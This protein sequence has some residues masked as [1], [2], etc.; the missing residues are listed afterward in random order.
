MVKSWLVQDQ[1]VLGKDYSNLLIADSLLKTIWFINAPCYG[2]E[3]LASPK[4]NELTIPEQTATGKGKSNPFMAAKDVDEDGKCLKIRSRCVKVFGY[5][6]QELKKINLKK[7]EVKQV[8]QSCL[9]EDCWELYIPDLVPVREP[10][11]SFMKPFGCPVTILNTLDPLGKFDGKAEEGFLVSSD[12]KVEDDTVDDDAFKK[13]VQKSASETFSPVGPSSG[14]SFVPFGGSFL[15]DVYNLP[16]DP[17][18]PELEDTV[19]I[20]S[21]SIFGNAYDDHDLETLNIP[22]ANQSVGAEADFNNME[23]SIVV[24]PIPTTRVHSTHP[25]A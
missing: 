15:I 3:A 10:N 2:N 23:P 25:K 1:T 24:N 21:T 13:T 7:H 20:R 12:D 5:I 6:L 17:L 14:P 19:K 11:I 22:Y 16:H 18:M 4:A 8:Q 9:G